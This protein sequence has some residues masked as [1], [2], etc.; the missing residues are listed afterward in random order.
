VNY[1]DL[2]KF[3]QLPSVSKNTSSAADVFLSLAVFMRQ[4]GMLL[5]RI[6]HIISR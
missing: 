4:L 5:H 6:A 3:E 1:A 2:S